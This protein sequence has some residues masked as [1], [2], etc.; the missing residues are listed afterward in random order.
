[1]GLAGLFLLFASTAAAYDPSPSN[2]LASAGSSSS[3]LQSDVFRDSIL[4]GHTLLANA[5]QSRFG[6]A[7]F[8]TTH[9]SDSSAVDGEAAPLGMPAE[10]QGTWLLSTLGAVFVLGVG[11][12]CASMFF[13]GPR[14]FSRW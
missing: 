1:M 2:L 12:T 10:S 6:Q 13:S 7:D 8:Q 11:L 3:E 14:G 9:L 5:N 4:N